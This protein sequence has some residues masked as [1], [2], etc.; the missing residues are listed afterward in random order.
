MTLKISP[1]SEALGA[2]ITGID[3]SK[4]LDD[5]TFGAILDALHAH[6]VIA[7]R[8][9]KLSPEQQIAFG[10]RFGGLDIHI[11]PKYKMKHHP[12]VLVL[13]NRKVDGEWVGSTKAGDEWHTDLHYRPKP[14]MATML[15]ALEVPAAGGETAF[16]DIY[17]AYDSLPEAIRERIAGLRSVNSWNR[18]R[19][20]RVKISEQHGDGKAQYDTGDPDVMHPI[21]RTHPATGRKALYVSPRH[22]LGIEGMGEAEAEE[23]LQ[24]LFAH[25]QRPEF[26]YVHKWRLGDVVIWDNRCTLHKAM[27]NIEPPGIRHLHRVTMTGD[28]PA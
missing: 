27:G 23:L 8:D 17:G 1:L 20:K 15:H 11:S 26:I 14:S 16:T 21:V 12:E 10:K 6:Q 13:S 9:Q 2:E 5:A 7:I 22:T 19:N 4:P 24:E 25:Q 18:L 28:V 3:A